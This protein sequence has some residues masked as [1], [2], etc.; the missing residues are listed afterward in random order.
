MTQTG[1][2]PMELDRV[3]CHCHIPMW[4]LKMRLVRQHYQLRQMLIQLK[5]VLKHILPTIWIMRNG[6][7]I[8][9]IS[10]LVACCSI[11]INW[12]TRR[13]GLIWKWGPTIGNWWPLLWKGLFR[14][15]CTC[16]KLAIQLNHSKIYNLLIIVW[17]ITHFGIRY[18]IKK[19]TMLPRIQS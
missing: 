19:R 11:N 10:V 12:I 4:L 15:I 14:A 7:V 6:I 16:L 9:F 5:L 2:R 8:I 1:L 18:I 3:L 13:H 17:Y